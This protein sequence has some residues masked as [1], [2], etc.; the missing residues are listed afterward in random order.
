[1]S[2]PATND[3][4]SLLQTHAA[5]LWFLLTSLNN[6]FT[7]KEYWPV[8]LMQRAPLRPWLD[9]S[10]LFKYLPNFFLYW[11]KEWNI[12]II[13]FYRFIYL[14]YVCEYTIAI[15]MLV[16]LHVVVGNRDFRT[17]VRSGQPARSVLARSCPKIYLLLYI[18]IHC[19][20]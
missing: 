4:E 2:V 1:M 6:T 13:Y 14:C 18:I 16:S 10:I 17:S 8:D 19:T 12:L 3:G 20:L 7:N 9:D 5:C 15:Q 11:S